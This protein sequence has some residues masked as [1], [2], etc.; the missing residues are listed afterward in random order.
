MHRDGELVAEVNLV[1]AC[2]RGDLAEVEQFYPEEFICMLR[3][4][5]MYRVGVTPDGDPMIPHKFML[6]AEAAMAPS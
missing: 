4:L 5:D 1:F 2:L 3:G 6:D